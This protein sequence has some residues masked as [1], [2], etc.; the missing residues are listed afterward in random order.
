MS[1]ES[2]S[3]DKLMGAMA[4]WG[5]IILS[6]IPALVIFILK[7]DESPFLKKHAL[8]ALF[9]NLAIFAVGIVLS[10]VSGLLGAITLGVGSLLILLV[11]VVLYIGA[12]IYMVVLGL[13]VFQ[14][15]DPEIPYI[16]DL[17]RKNMGI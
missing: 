4:Y 7:K 1:N 3:N 12:L 9:L 8:Q 6:F 16:T 2:D 14:G 15:D 13:Q 5:S 10:L 11:Q 17:L